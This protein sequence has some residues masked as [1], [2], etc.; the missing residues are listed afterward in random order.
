[1]RLVTNTIPNVIV[2]EMLLSIILQ[3]TLIK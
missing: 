1:M 2:F 3:H